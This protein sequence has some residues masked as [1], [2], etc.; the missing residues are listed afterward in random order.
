MKNKIVFSLLSFALV[1]GAIGFI[2]AQTAHAQVAPSFPVGC[3]SNLGYSVTN[4]TP[5]NGSSFATTSISGCATALGYS[6]TTGIPCDGNATAISYLAGC[7]S[8]YGFSNIS[9]AACDGTTTGLTTVVTT[10][11]TPG[12]PVTGTGSNALLNIVLLLASATLVVVGS[13]Y[14]FKKQKA[15]V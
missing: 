6:V 1:F 2:G 9:G 8:I 3:T 12:L 7:T 4:G 5:C 13:M 14:V 10:T 11:P 15:T